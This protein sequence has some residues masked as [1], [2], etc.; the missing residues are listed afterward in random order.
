MAHKPFKVNFSL[1]LNDADSPKVLKDG[2]CSIAQDCDFDTKGSL[3]SRKFKKILHKFASPPIT[4]FPYS[5]LVTHLKNGK[6]YDR[7]TLINSNLYGSLPYSAVEYNGVA[8]LVNK[9]NQI[10]YN[11]QD[12]YNI[13]IPAPL[14]NPFIAEGAAGNLTGIY[15]YKYTFEDVYGLESNASPVS[16]ALTVAAKQ[17]TISIPS[18]SLDKVSFVKL[19]RIGGTLADYYLVDRISNATMAASVAVTNVDDDDQGDNAYDVWADDNFIYLANGTGGLHTYSIDE[20]GTLTNVDSD[21]QGDEARG[22]WGDGNFI[23]LANLTGGLHTYSV[24]TAGVLTHIDSDDYYGGDCNKAWGDGK[25]VYV[26]NT[27]GGGWAVI[28]YQVSAGGALTSKG[29]HGAG[30]ALGAGLD[31]YAD[32]NFVYLACGTEGLTT[33]SINENG[34]FAFIDN[35]D[36]GGTYYGVWGD[37]NFIYCACGADG[38]RA[39]SVDQTGHLTFIDSDDQGDDARGVWGDG[40]YIY[41]A[42]LTG[43][44]E[45]YSVD[46]NG[47]LT[48]LANDDQGDNARA[49][50]STDD[51]VLLAN[52]TGGLLSYYIGYPYTDNIADTSLATLFDAE[53]NDQPPNGLSYITEHYQRLIGGKTT[54]YP[55]SILYTKE[56][57]PESWGDNLNQQY[58]LGGDDECTGLISWGRYVVFTKKHMAYIM[59]GTDPG[60]WHKRRAD[61]RRGNIAPFALE[62]WKLPILVSYDGLF[63]FDG[64]LTTKFSQQV[65]NWFRSHKHQLTDACGVVME[66][67]YYLGVDDS[68]LIFDFLN[69]RFSTYDFGLTA[70]AYDHINHRLLGGVGN[71]VVMLN[72]ESPDRIYWNDDAESVHFKVKSKAYSLSDDDMSGKKGKL[73]DYI[74]QINTLGEDVTFN[75]Y[76]DGDLKQTITLNTSSMEQVVRTFNDSLDGMYAEFEL[77]YEGTKRIQVDGSIIIN[78]SRV[79]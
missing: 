62:F 79:K 64:N 22:V 36:Q 15:Y 48:H 59:E 2:E 28:S 66:D 26:A 56:Y 47:T 30:A 60:S 51:Y 61:S 76:I 44:I 54:N 7:A 42:N 14:L 19:Y 53:N 70:L 21:D 72:Y 40:N 31:V 74:L 58:L 45:V 20:D 6:I 4:I 68:T 37:G 23:Y 69:K 52:D 78:G 50:F 24:D 3:F 41:L 13:G 12:I 35:D 10:R 38:I 77:E 11:G 29:V 39:Y 49:V 73:K 75:V 25:W 33:F 32:G 65:D 71:D 16:K 63:L 5:N 18:S 27:R 1:G 57:Y 34:S 8:Y 46:E 55:N 9:L 43:G 17:V 67:K